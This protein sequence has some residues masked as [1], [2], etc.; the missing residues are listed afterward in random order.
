MYEYDLLD[1]F[2]E[3]ITK[4]LYYLLR[5]AECSARTVIS[6]QNIYS[7]ELIFKY[8]ESKHFHFSSGNADLSF[9][10]YFY[11]LGFI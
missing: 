8:L 11:I 3:H 1:I 10:K 2:V 7:I 9:P 4:V 5:L 6:T